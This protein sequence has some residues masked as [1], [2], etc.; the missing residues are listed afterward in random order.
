MQTFLYPS[1]T[2]RLKN[3]LRSTLRILLFPVPTQVICY[4]TTLYIFPTNNF[5]C[6]LNCTNEKYKCNISRHSTMVPQSKIVRT[7]QEQPAVPRKYSD[8]DRPRAITAIFP[9]LHFNRTGLARH[10]IWLFLGGNLRCFTPR[11]ILISMLGIQL[12]PIICSVLSPD[13]RCPTTSS[14]MQTLS[15]LSSATRS[16]PASQRSTRHCLQPPVSS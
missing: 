14:P 7:P 8:I 4:K 6:L 9:S 13:S 12:S 2:L 5:Q 3:N 10:E 15:R 16:P 1:M 11:S